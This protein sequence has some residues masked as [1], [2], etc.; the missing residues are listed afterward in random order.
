M[1]K[2]F[3]KRL[4]DKLKE[5]MFSLNVDETTA[6]NIEEK[7]ILNVMVRFFNDNAAIIVA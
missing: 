6:Q 5:C 2:E 1:A 7:N 3:K 4:S